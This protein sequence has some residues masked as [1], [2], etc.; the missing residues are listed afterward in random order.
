MN[1]SRIQKMGRKPKDGFISP[2]RSRQ[3][4][5]TKLEKV[6]GYKL[7][8][9]ICVHHIN[10]NPFD[11][12]ISNLKALTNSGHSRLHLKEWWEQLYSECPNNL[13]TELE[14]AIRELN[15]SYD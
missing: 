10:G 9:N 11:N 6:L 15:N 12:D 7:A 14:E 5:R 8:S 2:C 4:A 3:I 1:G 13:L